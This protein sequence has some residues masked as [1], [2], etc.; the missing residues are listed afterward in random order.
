MLQ[1]KVRNTY[2]YLIMEPYVNQHDT[3]LYTYYI[4]L[5]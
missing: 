1:T 3:D 4:L 5:H 2:M